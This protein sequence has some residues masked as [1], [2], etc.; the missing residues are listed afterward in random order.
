MKHLCIRAS[1]R[2]I[3]ASLMAF[4]SVTFAVNPVEG[5]YAG[6]YLGVSY[7]PDSMIT[8]A[9][10]YRE[11]PV[12][13]ASLA[14]GVLG[15]VG[16]EIG[17]RCGHLRAEGQVLYN[18]NPYSSITINN[19]VING[20]RTTYG[21]NV[22]ALSMKG[23]KNVGAALIN[24]FFDLYTPSND[25]VESVAPYVGLGVGY[26]YVQNNIT[27]QMPNPSGVPGKVDVPYG[28]FWKSYTSIAGQAIVGANYFMDDFTTL[29]IDFRFFSTL[30][31]QYSG[32][33]KYSDRYA[34]TSFDAKTQIYSANII[35]NGSFDL[36]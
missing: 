19:L 25:N 36:A 17:Y 11:I 28:Q 26:A 24:G 4:S 35:F 23:Q 29:G 13:N 9:T 16:G 31:Q 22:F 30:N 21:D 7:N 1:V 2:L 18:N 15:G 32:R 14:Y 33:H 10:P 20:S 27:F 8:L 12:G 3:T 34:F 6:L 5:W